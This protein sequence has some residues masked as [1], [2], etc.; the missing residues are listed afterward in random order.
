MIGAPKYDHTECIPYIVDQ[1]KDNGFVV[2]YT[3]PNLLL[4][5]GHIGYQDM[6]GEIKK[7]LE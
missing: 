3:H 5:L 4:Y 6:L 1:L 7:K 2:R